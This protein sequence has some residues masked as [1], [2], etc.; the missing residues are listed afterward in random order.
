MAPVPERNVIG[1]NGVAAWALIAAV[2]EGAGLETLALP[3]DPLVGDDQIENNRRGQ[4][5]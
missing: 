1:A 4:T 2:Q 3:R 5:V